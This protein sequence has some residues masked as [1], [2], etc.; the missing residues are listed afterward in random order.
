M[1]LLDSDTANADAHLHV[2]FYECE[3]DPYKGT[4]FVRIMVPGDKTN[5]IDQPARDNHKARFPRAWLAFQAKSVEGQMIGTPLLTWHQDRPGEFNEGQLEELI[6]LKFQ[7]VEQFAT[8][9]DAQIQRIGMGANGLRERAR[10]YLGARNVAASG[11]ELEKTKDELFMLKAAFERMQAEMA[12]ARDA[13]PQEKVYRARGRRGRPPRKEKV[14]V[15]V[16]HDNAA[17][18]A[19]GG[20]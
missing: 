8:A 2:E 19:A 17:A 9:S 7:T 11:A 6:I 1:P 4:P 14:S 16:E 10:V 15:N 12:A 3:K 20:Q 5:I 18:H 13:P